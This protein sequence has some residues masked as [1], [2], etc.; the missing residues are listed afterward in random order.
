ME[1]HKSP[2]TSIDQDPAVYPSP[3]IAVIIRRLEE[4]IAYRAAGAPLSDE[5]ELQAAIDDLTP[6]QRDSVGPALIALFEQSSNVEELE[7]ST[8]KIIGVFQARKRDKLTLGQIKESLKESLHSR[9]SM[10]ANEEQR[11]RDA[12][13]DMLAKKIIEQ[14]SNDTKLI[15]RLLLP[16]KFNETPHT[17]NPYEINKRIGRAGI[18]RGTIRAHRP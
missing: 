11:L 4:A 3:E 2:I 5:N 7:I 14:V 10:L 13:T 1:S 12:L 16:L 8:E 17:S 15:Y 18:D 9:R 6:E